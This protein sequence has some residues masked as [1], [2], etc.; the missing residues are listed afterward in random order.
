[1]FLPIKLLSEYATIPTRTKE[2]DAGLDLYSAVDFIIIPQNHVAIDT[3]IAIEIPSGYYG[4]IA[5][6]SGLAYK[7]GIDVLAGVV[8][9]GFRGELKVI[10]ANLGKETFNIKKGDRIAQLIITPYLRLTPKSVEFLN[11]TERGESGFGSSGK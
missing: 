7:Y 6:R 11:E 5:P 8:D 9:A 2:G 3:N 10:L 4:R 1:M